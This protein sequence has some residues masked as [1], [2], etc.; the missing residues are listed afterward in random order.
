MQV[1][2]GF[3]SFPVGLEYVIGKDI[4]MREAVKLAE[5]QWICEALATTS[6]NIGAAARLLKMNRT[7]LSMKL[8]K[9]KLSGSYV[10]SS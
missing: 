5:L 9:L 10:K 1:S 2:E 6:G 7:T 8:K 3:Q 4:S